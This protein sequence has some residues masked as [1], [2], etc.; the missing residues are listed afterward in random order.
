[1]STHN[2][3]FHDEISK[4]FSELSQDEHLFC[5]SNNAIGNEQLFVDWWH[6]YNQCCVLNKDLEQ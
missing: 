4:I 1:M 5:F 2:L 3:C 6:G